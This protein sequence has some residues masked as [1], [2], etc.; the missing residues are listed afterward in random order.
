[1]N[2]KRVKIVIIFVLMVLSFCAV[3]Y[4][5][6]VHTPVEKFCREKGAGYALSWNEGP[7]KAL[8]TCSNGVKYQTRIAYVLDDVGNV[9]G[10]RLV[11]EQ[12]IPR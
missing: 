8:V 11:D 5:L 3:A 6:L 10:Y 12:P 2:L 4:A 7:D 9:V 1:M